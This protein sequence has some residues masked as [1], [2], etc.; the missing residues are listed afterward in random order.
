MTLTLL[1]IVAYLLGSVPS[2]LWIGQIFFGKNLRD[3]G[4]GNTGTTNTFRVLGKKAGILVF[5]LDVLK[6]LL[7]T[8]FPYWFGISPASV[9]GI[10]FGLAA[11]LGHIFPIFAGFKGGKAVATTFGALIGIAPLY[12]IY[13]A[14]V[15]TIALYLTSM[16]SFASITTAVMGILGI[17]LF[18]LFHVIIPRYE[19][20]FS[21]VFILVGL[22]IIWLHRSNI[23]RIL[24]HEE[25]TI[26][27]G[28]NLTHQAKK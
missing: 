2:G 6:G 9:W 23:S 14:C 12:L 1:L 27:W 13:C 11:I 7:P 4:S 8:L 25:S 24:K 10:V 16:I 3:Y 21:I 26:S 22:G 28:L 20:L 15:F 5:L 18:P 17:C 19:P